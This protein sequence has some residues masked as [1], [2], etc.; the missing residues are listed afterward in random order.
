MKL[1]EAIRLGAMLGPQI[2]GRTFDGDGSCALGSAL[3]AIGETETYTAAFKHFPVTHKQAVH[4]LSGA[5]VSVLSIVR[6]L[7]DADGWTREQIADWVATIEP[8]D[9]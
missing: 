2:Q 4:P 7:N 5:S 1:S 3:L 6:M 9:V 8:Q